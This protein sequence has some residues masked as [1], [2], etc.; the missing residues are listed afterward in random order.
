MKYL[1]LFESQKTDIELVID[2]LKYIILDEGM[3]LKIKDGLSTSTFCEFKIYDDRNLSDSCE[4]RNYS[5]KRFFISD[6][7]NEFIDRLIEQLGETYLIS[8]QRTSGENIIISIRRSMNKVRELKYGKKVL[9]SEFPIFDK[10]YKVEEIINDFKYIIED[11][12]KLELNLIKQQLNPLLYE[13][14]IAFETTYE[15]KLFATSDILLEFIDR[16]Q[17]ELGDEYEVFITPTT[18]NLVIQKSVIII[19]IYEDKTKKEETTVDKIYKSL[20]ESVFSDVELLPYYQELLDNGYYKGNGG[21][22]AILGNPRTSKSFTMTGHGYLDDVQTFK[23]RVED[24]EKAKVLWF[25]DKACG[26]GTER[27]NEVQIACIEMKLYEE[28]KTYII[29]F[30]KEWDYKIGNKDGLPQIYKTAYKYSPHNNRLENFKR[31]IP[32]KDLFAYKNKRGILQT[33]N[34]FWQEIFRKYKVDYITS[35]CVIK[36]AL[37]E[38]FNHKDLGTPMMLYNSDLA[39]VKTE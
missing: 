8:G 31:P 38:Y 2:Q 29:D 9:E 27:A 6:V 36:F 11:E 3:E 23:E 5:I 10:M 18:Y 21:L 19:C 7:F 20:K 30:L 25:V 15:R 35:Q 1:K 13:L 33:S 32:Y 24:F 17:G 37:E 26:K 39:K 22:S 4:D 16:L 28:M 14:E 12:E 34:E